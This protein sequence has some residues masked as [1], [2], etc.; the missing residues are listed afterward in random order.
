MHYSGNKKFIFIKN[1]I[2]CRQYYNYLGEVSHLQVLF[3]GELLK[4]PLQSLHGTARKRPGF[5]KNMQE[6]SEMYYSPSIA[7][8]VRNRVRDCEICVQD[9][10]I[11]DTR[12][13]P[14]IIHNPEWDLGP[15]DLM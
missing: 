8:Y 14:E 6:F 10:R 3:P 7:T 11:S 4:V 12:I 13:T 2:L 5:S 15:E 9:K 1:D